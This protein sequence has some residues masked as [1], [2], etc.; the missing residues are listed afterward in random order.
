MNYPSKPPLKG[1]NHN[2]C[3][4]MWNSFM[5]R[6]AVFSPNDI[7]FCPTTAV[8]PPSK[9]ISYDDAKS[10]HYRELK[11]GNYYYHVDAYIHFYIHD[12]KFD[13]KKS[14]IWLY[15]EK[16]LDIIS[17]FSGLIAP[18]FSTYADF[19]EPLKVW[20]IYRMNA[21][22][23]WIS[24]Q[25]IP[26]ISNVRWGT[27]ETWRYCFDGNPKESMLALGTVASGIQLLKNRPLF[28][29]GLFRMVEILKPHTLV[30]Y[31]SADYH[32]FDTIRNQ[33]VHIVP[34][35]SKTSEA[36]AGRKQHE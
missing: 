20:N 13:G 26:V 31:G 35:P 5:V 18:D 12:Q 9:M 2:C 14:S 7:P 28:E 24:T 17:H 6:E 23:Y 30:V 25:G 15:P 27:E 29:A 4:D 34:F 11:K 1:T 16:A 36:F 19:P 10:I 22:G 8:L 32:C 3:Q 21:F 33:G